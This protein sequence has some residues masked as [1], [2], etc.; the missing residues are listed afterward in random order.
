[1]SRDTSIN[2][3]L[4]V[5]G[6]GAKVVEAA[7]VLLAAGIGPGEIHV[8]LIDQDQ[9]NGNVKRT[10][11][12]LT[13]L[14]RFRAA[15]TVGDDRVDW[16]GSGAPAFGRTVVHPLF[17]DDDNALWCPTKTHGTLNSILGEGLDENQQHLFDLMFMEGPEEQDLPLSKGYRGRAHVG[18]TA[19]VASLIDADSIL[20]KRLRTLMEDSGRNRVNV[21][22]VGS[23]FGGTGAAGFPT[24]ARALNRM[25]TAPSFKNAGMVSLGGMLMLPYFD[26]NHPDEN[27]PDAVV[28]PDE[29]LP[30]ARLALEYYDNL[31]RH[32]AT[33]DR[34]YA[35][36]WERF[37]PL[38]YHEA[39]SEAQENPPLPPE[40]FAA[41]AAFD[42]FGS[43][44]D[45]E[46]EEKVPV[47]VS[48]R[49]DAPI[50][51][52]DLPGVDV[53]AKL[54]QLL[55]FAFYWKYVT[56]PAL[57]E[58][59]FFKNWAQKIANGRK[60]ADAVGPLAAIDAV[61]DH[62]LLWALTIEFKG[63]PFWQDGPWQLKDLHDAGHQPTFQHPVA[64]RDGIAD[65]TALF[66]VFDR[67]IRTDDG[68]PLP[69][70]GAAL[71]KELTPANAAPGDHQGIGRT[72]ATV[73][74]AA[75]MQ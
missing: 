38:G 64:L 54:G 14:R 27:A 3:L 24:L 9:S 4:G 53:Q 73:Y 36:G 20:L 13:K 28:T 50:R 17:P 68:Q 35:L 1:M 55:R 15:W 74:A 75:R 51:W 33:F 21:F 69:R 31:L 61:V 56:Q 39:G 2:I 11:Q 41:T 58:R 40:L 65:E 59:T 34:F 6:T 44:H 10:R 25:R 32:E 18:A 70:A 67:M 72:F 16:T 45:D 49:R 62:V 57:R 30:K 66:D 7:L 23:A 52:S 71:F 5:G 48:A 63:G 22:V 47:L 60:V 43:A 29:L 26:F 12:L 8:G 19:L 42:F 37:F 46:A